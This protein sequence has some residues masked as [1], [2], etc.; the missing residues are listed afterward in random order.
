M[1]IS[2][3]PHSGD[4]RIPNADAPVSEATVCMFSHSCVIQ[5]VA[6]V[7]FVS[8]SGVEAKPTW[9]HILFTACHNKHLTVNPSQRRLNSWSDDWRAILNSK[10][11]WWGPLPFTSNPINLN[12]SIGC[13]C[14][15]ISGRIQKGSLQ[16]QIYSTAILVR[17]LI[18]F[19]F[20]PQEG[21]NVI[22]SGLQPVKLQTSK[23]FCWREKAFLSLWYI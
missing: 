8:W 5:I 19:Y 21:T 16:E 13:Q 17:F 22:S 15:Q 9:E 4:S 20:W 12:A 1:I 6:D 10:R 7:T 3:E 2:K 23:Q 11:Q 14:S 18:Y